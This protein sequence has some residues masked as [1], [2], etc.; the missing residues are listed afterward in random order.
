M[1][2]IRSITI[3]T[4]FLLHKNLPGQILGGYIYRYPV[5]TALDVLLLF[6]ACIIMEGHGFNI[7]LNFNVRLRFGAFCGDHFGDQLFT[8]RTT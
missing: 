1:Y 4:P 5:A 8:N 7:F 6:V 2:I 3:K